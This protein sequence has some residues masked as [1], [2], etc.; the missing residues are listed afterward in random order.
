MNAREYNLP[1]WAYRKA[2][3]EIYDDVA[4]AELY[5]KYVKAHDVDAMCSLLNMVAMGVL[6]SRGIE[7]EAKRDNL[8]RRLVAAACPDGRVAIDV[9]SI[10]CDGCSGSSLSWLEEPTLEEWTRL[11]CDIEEW[12]EGRW[13]MTIVP[14]ADLDTYEPA[15]FRDLALEAF[16]DGHQHIIYG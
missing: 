5:G 2:M 10:D 11:Q 8:R 15:P 4:T 13:E 12:A 9:W 16:E 6:E 1:T 3:D 7:H 14:A